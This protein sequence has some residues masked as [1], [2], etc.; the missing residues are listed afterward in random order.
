MQ[1][2]ANQ[3]R[4]HMVDVDAALREYHD[5]RTSQIPKAAIFPLGDTKTEVRRGELLDECNYHAVKIY[6]KAEKMKS[7]FDV[8]IT[9]ERTQV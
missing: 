5:V 2:K 4:A 1:Y 6:E 8:A 7:K 9:L 3:Q